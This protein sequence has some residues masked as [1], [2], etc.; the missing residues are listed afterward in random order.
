MYSFKYRYV[1]SDMNVKCYNVIDFCKGFEIVYD[2]I[3]DCNWD[4]D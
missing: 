2:D 3:F 1:Y 4:G